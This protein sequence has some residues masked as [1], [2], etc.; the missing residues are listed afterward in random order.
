MSTATG[1]GPELVRELTA[2]SG[3][4]AAV[5]TVQGPGGTG[6]SLLLGELTAAHERA[7]L[8][9]LDAVPEDPSALPGP[10]AV[11]VDD[12]HRLTG[13]DVARLAGLLHSPTA[14]VVLAL[15]PWPRPPA[16]GALLAELGPARRTVVLGHAD[17]AQLRTWAREL[18]GEALAPPFAD[19]VLAQTGGLPALAVP[20]LRALGRR[21]GVPAQAGRIVVPEEVT[22]RARDALAA[23]DEPT[24]A[25]LHALAAGAPLD[26]D[27]LGE[28][29]GVPPDRAVDLLDAGRATGLLLDTGAVVPLAARALLAA[30]PPD[31]T[32]APAASCWPCWWSAA[33][34][35]SSWPVGWPRTRCVTG[36]PRGCW[37]GTARRR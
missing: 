25:L 34:S 4:A 32:A 23:A 26:E 17:R 7:G 6:K 8:A 1:W 14:R 20:M 16:L 5:V 37:S 21:G 31:V 18:L 24:R 29:L 13:T 19:T 11:L 3:R 15:R 28:V 22:D 12:A 9:V 27:V 30:T 2:P 33:T 36:T 35:P 10:V